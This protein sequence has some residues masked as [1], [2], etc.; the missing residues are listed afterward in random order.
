MI[1]ERGNTLAASEST[2]PLFITQ[3][4]VILSKLLCA[5]THR[6]NFCFQTLSCGV[7]S[8]VI[9]SHNKYLSDQ[10]RRRS[11]NFNFLLISNIK[12]SLTQVWHWQLKKLIRV[13]AVS[14]VLISL[15][16]FLQWLM[17]VKHY[18]NALNRDSVV[19]W[20]VMENSDLVSGRY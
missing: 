19:Q 18:Q 14:F 1:L 4:G 8:C 10:R 16:S 6:L 2:H 20:H 11:N 7:W 17:Q 13:V 9:S 12:Q 15:T 5:F 3:Q